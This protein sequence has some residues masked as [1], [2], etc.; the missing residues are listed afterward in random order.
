MK[1]INTLILYFTFFSILFA[2][3]EFV[4]DPS[5]FFLYDDRLI[6]YS[7][8]SNGIALQGLEI[9][10]KE[11]LV[12]HYIPIFEDG[13]PSWIE[14]IQ[15]WNNTNE[16][17]APAVHNNGKYIF[18]TVT[19]E[20]DNQDL[21][22]NI[23]DAIGVVQ[24][25]GTPDEPEWND[26]GIVVRSFGEEL[27]TARTMDP[28]LI[29]VKER[30]FLIFGS[31]AGGI[32]LTELNSESMKLK[33]SPQITSTSKYKNRFINLAQHYDS[34][35]EESEIEAPFLYKKGKY[36][37]LFVNW[38]KCCRGID[39]TYNIRIGRSLS[40]KG[41]Y[42]DKDKKSMN[43]GGG[44]VFIKSEER[45]IGPGHV[46]IVDIENIGEVIT[47]HFYDSEDDGLSKLAAREL[48]WTENGWPKL[49]KH[50]ISP[51]QK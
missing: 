10:L 44:S 29:R 17:D 18:Y 25:Y 28:S 35:G 8:G 31:H 27:D 33:N 49:G 6:G 9:V 39:S 16:L 24:N 5:R 21:V 7:S 30:L 32:F 42:V 36:F 20:T 14:K 48:L 22:Y 50:L 46:G 26:L 47:Y 51:N 45:F 1:S 38:G 3:E 23:Q 37:Y 11:K 15:I 41:P 13:V 12:E 34:N 40:I 4:H 43:S 19:D 2:S